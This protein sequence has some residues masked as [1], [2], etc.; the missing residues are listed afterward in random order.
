LLNYYTPQWNTLLKHLPILKSSSLLI[1]W[2]SLYIPVVILLAA[3]WFDRTVSPP[4][5][6][7]TMVLLSLAVVVLLNAAAPRR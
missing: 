1:R 3:V 2:V 7:P 5:Y 6:Q 4:P